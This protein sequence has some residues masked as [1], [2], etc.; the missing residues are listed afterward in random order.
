MKNS[1]SS[2]SY[3]TRLGDATSSANAGNSTSDSL[4]AQ[5]YIQE[6]NNILSSQL[7]LNEN[8]Y[9]DNDEDDND[10]IDDFSNFS[11]TE[12]ELDEQEEYD[13]NKTKYHFS[14]STGPYFTNFTI[15]L[16]FLWITKY[17]IGK[18]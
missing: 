8:F 11:N 18:H 13:G 12:S 1:S 15:F 7:Q 3:H 6:E 9:Y 4:D 5:E 16:L 2:I 14:G 10:N 17:Q